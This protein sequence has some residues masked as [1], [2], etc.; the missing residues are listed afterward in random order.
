MSVRINTRRQMRH[1]KSTA[2]GP[3]FT[4]VELLVVIGIIALLI[5]ILLPTLSKARH[6]ARSTASLSNLRQIGVGLV[7]YRVHNRGYYPL[8]AWQSMKDRARFRWADAIYPF[9]RNTEVYMSPH[10]DENERKRM[11]KPFHHTVDPN[12]NPGILPTS[13]FFGGYGYNWQYLG[14]GRTWPGVSEYF[15][16]ESA[17]RASAKTIAVADTNGSKNGGATWTSEGVYVIDPPLMS[18]ELGSRGSRKSSATPGPGNYGYTG[19]NDGDPL[20]RSTPAERNNGKV[21]VL[22]CDGHAQPMTLREMDDFNQDG[23]P[24]NGW[25]N[26]KADPGLR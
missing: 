18:L 26:G 24:D 12:A 8:A 16:K 21:N 10:L 5:A 13:V 6:A 3:A 11:N 14:N 7:Q 9:M 25:W 1:R 4:L 19:G 23:Q 2:S 17:I 22:F 20:H 15:A